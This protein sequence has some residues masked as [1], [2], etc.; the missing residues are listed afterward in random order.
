[1]KM[2][3]IYVK[4]N[5]YAEHIFIWIVSHKDL[6]LNLAKADS[7]MAYYTH[8]KSFEKCPLWYIKLCLKYTFI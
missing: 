2:R 5:F 3:W 1:M 7:K 6:F 4:V 8:K